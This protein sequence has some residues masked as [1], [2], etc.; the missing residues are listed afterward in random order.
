MF[1]LLPHRNIFFR[2]IGECSSNLKQVT[3][4]FTT[5]E[6]MHTFLI[7]MGIK[8]NKKDKTKIRKITKRKSF[9]CVFLHPF[10]QILI[11]SSFFSPEIQVPSTQKSGFRYTGNHHRSQDE[12]DVVEGEFHPPTTTRT[13]LGVKVQNGEHLRDVFPSGES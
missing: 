6:Y 13:V 12:A 2:Q 4:C 5:E 9:V 11:S 3:K 1:T 10:Q 7:Y 8:Q